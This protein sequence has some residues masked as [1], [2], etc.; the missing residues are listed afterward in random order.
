M[1]EWEVRGW[2]IIRKINQA[3]S[4]RQVEKARG[5]LL[6]PPLAAPPSGREAVCASYSQVSK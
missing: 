2:T 5:E 3:A 1:P 6:P 4:Y